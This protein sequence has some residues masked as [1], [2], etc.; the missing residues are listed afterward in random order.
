LQR[1]L[2]LT[3]VVAMASAFALAA[4]AEEGFFV[5]D[6][7]PAVRAAWHSVFALVCD[8]RKDSYTATAFL[9][10]K[11]PDKRS[12]KWA[13][14]FFVTAGH[15]VEICKRRRRALVANLNA[16][17]FEADGITVAKRPGRF[18]SV[19]RVYVDDAY[20]LAIVKITANANIR[21]GKP[22]A[23]DASCAPKLRE[24]TYTIGFP[25]V[26]TRGSLKLKRETKR[27]S[28]G[29]TVGLGVADFRGIDATYIASTVD[30]LPGSSGGPAIDAD[31]DLVGV[32]AKGA[33]GVDNKFRYD[34]DAKK[35]DD[36]QTFLAPCDA[37][38]R[39]LQRAGLG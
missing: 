15:A 9:V 33:S 19:E 34:V 23:V 21:I 18:K 26:S 38:L 13:E 36:W 3:F 11:K 22:I 35:P 4:A 39:I 31:G 7:P 24:Q 2:R 27:W 30:S 14:Y 28:K 25:G 6:K 12:A 17:R 5:K 1:G 32:V 20:D 8:G 16:P 10:A 37:V 29:K